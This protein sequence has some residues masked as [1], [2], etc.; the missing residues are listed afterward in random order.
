MSLHTAAADLSSLHHVAAGVGGPTVRAL[1]HFPTAGE[2]EA[3]AGKG[4][5]F[6]SK[7]CGKG[8]ILGVLAQEA[9]LV[10]DIDVGNNGQDVLLHYLTGLTFGCA[11]T[12]REPWAL[13]IML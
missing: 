12:F 7:E 5:T 13:Q 2:Q 8:A 10:H 4:E 6:R 1:V 11:S 3:A 9:T